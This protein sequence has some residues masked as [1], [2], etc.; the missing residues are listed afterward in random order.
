MIS[1]S[2]V[3]ATWPPSGSHAAVKRQPSGSQLAA[4]WHSFIYQGDNLKNAVSSVRGTTS[5]KQ[6]H[7]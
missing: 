7:L 2:D 6:F 1:D 4:K 5:K 3:A